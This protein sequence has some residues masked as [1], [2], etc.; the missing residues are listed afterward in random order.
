VDELRCVLAGQPWALVVRVA[1]LFGRDTD[2]LLG[3]AGRGPAPIGARASCGRDPMWA[4]IAG[5]FAVTPPWPAGLVRPDARRCIFRLQLSDDLFLCQVS[6]RRQKLEGADGIMRLRAGGKTGALLAFALLRLRPVAL[7][8]F[9]RILRWDCHSGSGQHL[10]VMRANGA[11]R[12][13]SR[14]GFAPVLQIR[15]TPS[16]LI[17]W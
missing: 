5:L 17:A 13:K 1:F 16:A 2:R 15:G 7:A 3:R 4:S 9:L 12:A 8:R 6:R 10:W 11:V 14:A